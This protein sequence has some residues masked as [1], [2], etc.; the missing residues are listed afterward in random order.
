MLIKELSKDIVYDEMVEAAGYLG[1]VALLPV[2]YEIKKKWGLF[3]ELNTSIKIL[4]H[5]KIKL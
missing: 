3:D 2:L 1:N 4:E 5:L